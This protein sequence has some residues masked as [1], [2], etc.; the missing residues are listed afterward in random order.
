[1]ARERKGHQEVARDRDGLGWLSLAVEMTSLW[2]TWCEQTL[3]HLFESV[4][5]A[6]G[7]QPPLLI[8]APAHHTLGLDSRRWGPG[9]GTGESE[10]SRW[11]SGF[12]RLLTLDSRP[13]TASR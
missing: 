13:G 4:V 2:G 12:A 9:F 10:D 8:V 3:S 5:R 1:M 11:E 7:P 6:K